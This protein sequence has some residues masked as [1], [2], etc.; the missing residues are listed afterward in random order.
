MSWDINIKA[1]REVSILE[2]NITYNLSDMYYKCVDKEKGLKIFDNMS[3]KEALPILQKAIEDLIDNKEGYQKL[4]PENGWGSYEGVLGT[5]LDMRKCCVD[6]P[7]G[8]IE[9]S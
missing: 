7:D 3:C 8:I 2:T 4:N 1:K 5:F 9:L 6:N